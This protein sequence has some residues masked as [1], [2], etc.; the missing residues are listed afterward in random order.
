MNKNA[1]KTLNSARKLLGMCD[2]SSLEINEA[3]QRFGG[4]T[5][6]PAS[7]Q[8]KDI[9]EHPKA[10]I[11]IN[12]PSTL[13]KK[14]RFV[15][16][17]RPLGHKGELRSN[18]DKV[19][20]ATISDPKGGRVKMFAFH[21]SHVSHQKAMDFAKKHKL[22]ARKDA[23]GRPLYAKESV[24]LQDSTKESLARFIGEKIERGKDGILRLKGA[25]KSEPPFHGMS[26]KA[27]D[28]AKARREAKKKETK[29]DESVELGEIN[30]EKLKTHLDTEVS[31]VTYGDKPHTPKTNKQAKLL[32]KLQRQKHK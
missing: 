13:S 28:A 14:A 24:E 3:N 26:Q 31:R 32:R 20:M 30:R 25:F 22:V 15:V 29:K 2:T 7:K 9:I 19:L 1:L 10:K 8:T 23:K 4:D 18:Q 11:L 12:V 16:I 6:I 5:N 27:W 21:G 17:Q